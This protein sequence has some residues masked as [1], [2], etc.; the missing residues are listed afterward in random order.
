M[1]KI[2]LIFLLFAFQL[3]CNAQVTDIDG[4]TYTTKIIGN[5]IWMIENLNTT[6]FNDGEP[7]IF[8]FRN[9]VLNVYDGISTYSELFGDRQTTY[10][11]N[12]ITNKI[13]P[14]GWRI[15]STN[16]WE[17]LE[18]KL[19]NN[20]DN[21]LFEHCA[22]IQ[23]IS[24]NNDGYLWRTAGASIWACSDE[25]GFYA[26]YD[27][28]VDSLADSSIEIL[29]SFSVRCIKDY[30]FEIKLTA[31][32]TTICKGNTVKIQVTATG[33]SPP[34]TYTWE[35]GE[36]GDTIITVI[37]QY[38]Y[39]YQ[40][41]VRDSLNQVIDKKIIIAVSE[42]PEANFTYTLN[43]IENSGEF[44]N[45]TKEI[46]LNMET[47][48]ENSYIWQFEET[49]PNISQSSSDTTK[50]ITYIFPGFDEYEVTLWATNTYGCKDSI[51]KIINTSE[52]PYISVPSAFSP[53]NDGLNDVLYAVGRNIENITWIIYD[54]WGQ[55]IFESNSLTNGWDGTF[56]GKELEAAVYMYYISGIATYDGKKIERKGDITIIK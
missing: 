19:K 29:P 51:T 20:E 14:N 47:Q 6:H 43:S 26:Y 56:N 54:R 25:L 46:R 5:Q 22:S 28:S 36:I 9:D 52:F 17:L 55:K 16:E 32:D 23:I 13:C 4:N 8:A 30:D 10:N 11:L 53:N 12:I 42:N 40:V 48:L 27:S 34:F 1:K 15:P 37:P 44:M 31:T 38:T 18:T 21:R 7:I 2:I 39:R 45:T 35:T 49:Q 50:P 33:E 24:G 3:Y 41:T